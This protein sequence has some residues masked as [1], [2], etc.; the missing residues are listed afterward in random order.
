MCSRIARLGTLLAVAIVTVGSSV[1]QVPPRMAG[2]PIFE[3]ARVRVLEF[4][5]KPNEGVCGAGMHS[6]P[7]HLTVVLDPADVKIT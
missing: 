1:A 4:D 6:H 7:A 3:N 2:K 5:A